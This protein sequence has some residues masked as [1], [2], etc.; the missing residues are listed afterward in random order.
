MKKIENEQEFFLEK[1]HS[2]EIK[3]DIR[4]HLVNEIQIYLDL[5]T[6]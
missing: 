1:V 3:C 2:F 4:T 6:L 5:T